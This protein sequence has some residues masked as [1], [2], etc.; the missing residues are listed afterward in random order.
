MKQG[1]LLKRLVMLLLLTALAVYFIIYIYAA[2]T[3]PFRSALCYSYTVYDKA[4]ATGYVLRQ[5]TP[6]P[7]QN[8]II[9]IL[10]NEGEKVA[11][12]ETI[13]M[14]YSDAQALE[15]KTDIRRLELELEQLDYS[16]R[17]DSGSG[18][19]AKLDQDIFAA[20]V[21]LRESVTRRD[22]SLLEDTSMELKNLVFRRNYTYGSGDGTDAIHAMIRDRSSQLSALKRENAADTVS[23]TAPM[24]G[25]YSGQTDGLESILTPEAAFSL[26]P[27]DLDGL[28]LRTVPSSSGGAGKLITDSRW[29]FVM[30]VDTTVGNRLMAEDTITVRFSRDF[31][32]DVPMRVE[33]VGAEE[34]GRVPVVLSSSR[35]LSQTTLLRR[36][37][38]ELIFH[39]HH[40]IRVPR[41]ALRLNEAGN[42]GVFALVGQQAEW[43]P[44][45]IL[46]EE[47]DFFLV[48][49]APFDN[50]QDVGEIKRTLRSGD[51]III[52]ANGLYNGKV[53]R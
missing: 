50:P 34:N 31:I 30:P 53:V 44:V 41:T 12:G 5:E 36:Q 15:R 16:L 20:M 27:S 45:T 25:I 6:L 32:G 14:V 39:S 49:P 51:E 35:A 40:G 38:V 48:E 10:P 3:T 46:A 17:R 4:E 42:T 28:H 21:T 33:Q 26:T 24:P 22:A 8:G 18:D 19:A 9:D 1:T 43:K 52:E 37:T 47:A 13:A 7:Q 2:L 29:Y 23:I 11:A